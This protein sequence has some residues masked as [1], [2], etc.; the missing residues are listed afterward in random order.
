MADLTGDLLTLR[1]VTLDQALAW[2]MALCM[3]M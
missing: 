2:R 1:Y 3:P